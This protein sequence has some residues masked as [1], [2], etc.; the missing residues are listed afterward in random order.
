MLGIRESLMRRRLAAEGGIEFPDVPSLRA[1]AITDFVTRK[2]IDRFDADGAIGE[3]DFFYSVWMTD[4]PELTHEEIDALKRLTPFLGSRSIT[5]PLA[6]I[7]EDPGRDLSRARRGPAGVA[8]RIERGVAD[9]IKAVLWF[10][11]LRDYTRISDSR[12]PS[13]SFRCSTITPTRSSRP[14]HAHCGDVLKLIGDGVL[15]IFPAED[16]ARA[17]AA[18]LDAARKRDGGRGAERAAR[19]RRTADHRHVSRR[20]ISAWCSTATSAARTGSTS[21]SSGRRST[22]CRRIAAMCRSVD[23]PILISAQL[24]PILPSA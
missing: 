16:R 22:K 19:R 24:S 11:D 14:I 2:I 5:L 1:A 17:C 10:S 6:R 18:A 15:A 9:R 23:Q 3:M 12:R 8:G 20:S 7:A 13:R 4:R 21:P